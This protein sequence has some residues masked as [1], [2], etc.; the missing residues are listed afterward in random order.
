MKEYSVVVTFEAANDEEAALVRSEITEGLQDSKDSGELPQ[1]DFTVAPAWP[2]IEEP[3]P[4]DQVFRDIANN[5]RAKDGDIEFDENAVVSHGADNGAYVQA[6]VWIP[7]PGS[8]EY[9]GDAGD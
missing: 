3:D 2:T 9:N 7:G 8:E 1:L 5:T 6:W 4:A